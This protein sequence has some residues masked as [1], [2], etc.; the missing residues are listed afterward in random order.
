MFEYRILPCR[1]SLL[2]FLMSCMLVKIMLQESRISVVCD[3][4]RWLG[5]VRAK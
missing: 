4:S 1:Y 3:G 2:L 5:K